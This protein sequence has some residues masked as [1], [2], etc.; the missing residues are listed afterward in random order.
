MPK[1]RT[2]LYAERLA[3]AHKSCKVP[4]CKPQNEC[5]KGNFYLKSQRTVG[6]T[7]CLLRLQSVYI[8]P[9][10]M[11][12]L[13]PSFVPSFLLHFN[14]K[15]ER[16]K[17]KKTYRGFGV[18]LRLRERV[19][20]ANSSCWGGPWQKGRLRERDRQRD[21]A[22][23]ERHFRQPVRSACVCV[24]M[25]GGY[26]GLGAKRKGTRVGESSHLVCSRGDSKTQRNTFKK[27]KTTVCWCMALL[28]PMQTRLTLPGHWRW[29]CEAAA[30]AHYDD[31]SSISWPPLPVLRGASSSELKR[32][33]ITARK[34]LKKKIFMPS[35]C[36]LR[37]EPSPTDVTVS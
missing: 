27:K 8:R 4:T 17:K 10:E 23:V 15:K 29:T 13:Y 9:P 25:V 36:N 30:G 12:A 18:I 1:N 21:R 14:G 33:R 2:K 16:K 35:P 11:N 20:A 3:P 31:V 19:R 24:C 37:S 5:L 6:S 26:F 34:S 7:S 22:K 28:T 32:R